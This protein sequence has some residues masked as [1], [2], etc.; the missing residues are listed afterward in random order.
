LT[1][2]LGVADKPGPVVEVP[3]DVWESS[4]LV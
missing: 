1:A 2:L 3:N 4:R